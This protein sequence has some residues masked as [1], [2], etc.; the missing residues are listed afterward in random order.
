MNAWMMF[1][2]Q[3]RQDTP[4]VTELNAWLQDWAKRLDF[5]LM[6]ERRCLPPHLVLAVGN[7][8]LLG[9]QVPADYGGRLCLSNFELLRVQRQ[10]GAIDLTLAFL[11]VSTTGWVSVLFNASRR[12]RSK[13]GTCRNWRMVECSPRLR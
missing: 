13:S 3:A 2:P 11:S 5:R 8:G 6:D 1:D 10:L 12:Q 4:A 9:M 7:R